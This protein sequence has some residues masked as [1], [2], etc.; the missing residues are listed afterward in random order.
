VFEISYAA[1]ATPATAPPLKLFPLL[2]D[3][4]ATEAALGVAV[5]VV[6]VFNVALIPAGPASVASV[7]DALPLTLSKSVAE[8]AGR[9]SGATVACDKELCTVVPVKS[10]NRDVGGRLFGGHPFLFGHS[11]PLIALASS[12]GVI[13]SA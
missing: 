10:P 13:M 11:T 5:M 7:L 9:P 2:E 4:T 12:P 3:D 1:I 6:N 8:A